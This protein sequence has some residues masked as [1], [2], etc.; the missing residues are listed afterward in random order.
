MTFIIS[1]R[2]LAA[3]IRRELAGL[4]KNLATPPVLGVV[5]VGSDAA[6][7]LYVKLK[8]E[9]AH[10]VGIDV[11]RVELPDSATTEEVIYVVENF[12]DDVNVN[13]I[14]VQLPLPAQIDERIVINSMDPKKDADGFHP[15]NLAALTHDEQAIVPGVS[16]GILRLIEQTKIPLVGKKALLLVNSR[17]FATPLEYLLKKQGVTCETTKETTDYRL[18]TADI[19]ISALGQPGAV[20]GKMIKDGAIVID[21]GT[22]K[23]GSRVV[24]DVDTAPFA[25]RPIYM[26]PVPGGVGPM[27]VAMLLMNVYRL[28]SQKTR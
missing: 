26:T 15:Q 24:G 9:A 1:G 10:E 5:L 25:N 18:Q 20:P 4:V 8:E 22:T 17:E 16:E 28:A 3:D 27:T 13:G 11:K 2:E 23:V 21:V 14:L 12:N 19:I 6:S 7:Q